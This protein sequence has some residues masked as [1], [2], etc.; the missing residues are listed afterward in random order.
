MGWFGDSWPNLYEHF[1]NGLVQLSRDVYPQK[2]S[3][4]GV[5]QDL[6]LLDAR[7]GEN[8]WQGSGFG[9]IRPDSGKVNDKDRLAGPMMSVDSIGT[10]SHGL[11][12]LIW[13]SFQD[14]Y[15]HCTAVNKAC[16][17][18]ELRVNDEVNYE[19]GAGSRISVWFLPT[20]IASLKLALGYTLPKFD[21][22]WKDTKSSGKVCF[23][24]CFQRSS[25]AEKIRTSKNTPPVS[26]S[27]GWKKES[28][29]SVTWL[30]QLVFPL[31]KPKKRVTWFFHKKIPP[32]K[33]WHLFF[34]ASRRNVTLKN[35][36][37]GGGG[38]KKREASRSDSRRR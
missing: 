23:S 36:G 32:K 33:R 14:L 1:S 10:C 38:A 29:Y 4:R 28:P 12:P 22:A 16:P 27:S 21:I 9:F 20:A 25:F 5:S 11:G 24:H 17:F 19:A 18:D 37:S 3:G 31:K 30:H 26:G 35:G 2:S 34:F 13:L 7:V 15:F 6:I 8:C